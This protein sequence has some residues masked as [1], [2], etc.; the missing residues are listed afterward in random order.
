[1]VMG[2]WR[3]AQARVLTRRAASIET[4]G[5]VTVLCTDK[6]GTLTENKMKLVHAE[7]EGE[8]WNRQTNGLAPAIRD[9]LEIAVLAG[10]QDP[11]DPMER[12]LQGVWR[13]Q[14]APPGALFDERELLEH[15]GI[16]AERLAMTQVWRDR[17][18]G[19]T[20]S[21]VKGAPEAVA[22]MCG[23]S[24][25]ETGKLLARTS[26]L[27]AH[28]LR[29]LAIAVSND[30][31][32]YRF[33]GLVGFE[34]PIRHG[35]P[36]A[37]AECAEA[38]IRV[39]MI[40]GDY[41]QTA[42]AIAMQ[43][44]IEA[45]DVLSGVELAR[46]DD[47]TLRERVKT[48]RVFARI[49]PE[50]K[51]LIVEALKANGEIVGMT[52]DGVNDAPSLRAAH[53]GI[54]MGGRGTDVAREASSIV[55]LDD[56]FGSIVKTIRL[57]RRIYDNLRKAM[58]YIVSVHVPIAG[59][60]LLPL[61][62]GGPLILT[63][64]LIAFLEMIIDPASSIVFEAE[65]EERD[66]MRRAPRDPRDRLLNRNV[67]RSGLL[68]GAL[69]FAIVVAVFL[70]ARDGAAS[71]EDLRTLVLV[72]LVTTNVGLI[73]AHRSFG[74]SIVEA[75]FRPNRWLWGGIAGVAAILTAVF[76]WPLTRETFGLAPLHP[77][78]VVLSLLAALTF[79]AAVWGLRR[80]LTP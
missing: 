6:T 73:F 19:A 11:F 34:D 23:L 42:R 60:A 27:A 70:I 63:P 41:P 76:L 80:L 69:A 18:T 75:F 37:I 9:L 24:A 38:G 62:F 56:D 54:A 8:T 64:A 57:G 67:L 3:I 49:L 7:A 14:A 51:L 47:A 72:A 78:D 21:A 46:L 28:G 30:G 25:P 39:V 15:R 33:L 58:G 31:A 68:L 71:T 4:L 53:I 43:A 32:A 79:L 55:L 13:E 61:A 77:D 2:A 40:T 48:C 16:S 44:G 17:T 52:G 26:A 65:A 66:L 1:M 74:S 59:L 45:G 22:K 29:V 12:A 10:L 36:A 5:A 50:Q 35:V 20:I